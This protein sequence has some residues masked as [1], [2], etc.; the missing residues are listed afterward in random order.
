MNHAVVAMLEKYDRRSLDEYL[1]AMRE[2]RKGVRLDKWV[3]WLNLETMGVNRNWESGSDA[4]SF[5]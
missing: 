2:K 1:N 5:Y 4:D 3:L